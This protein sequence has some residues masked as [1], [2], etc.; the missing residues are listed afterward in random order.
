LTLPNKFLLALLCVATQIC[1]LSLAHSTPLIAGE[2]TQDQGKNKEEQYKWKII[3]DLSTN[4]CLAVDI[5]AVDPQR[6]KVLGKY[7][8]KQEAVDALEAF[9]KKDDP[10]KAGYKMCE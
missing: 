7:K 8:T 2:R 10:E 1:A 4:S 9:K 6:P 3:R 5:A